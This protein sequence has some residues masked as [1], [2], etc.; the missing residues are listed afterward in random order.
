MKPR[1]V[2]LASTYPRW[3]DDHEPSF[4]H[5][6]ARRLTD[7][8]E[9]VAVV[10]HAP[11]AL[12]RET[13]DDVSILRYRYAP[14]RFETL[15]NDGGIVTHL[16]RSPWKWLLVPTFILMQWI[17]ARRHLKDGAVVHAHWIIPQ[18]VIARLLRRP[19]LITSH[20]ADLFAL[21]GR[22]A[23]SAKRYALAACRAVTVVSEAMRQPATSL[24]RT[25]KISVLPMG[26]DLRTRFTPD[27]TVA[28][29]P[30]HLLFVG[31]LVEKKGVDVLILALS[32]VAA[33][34]PAVRLTVVGHGPFLDA[35][36]AL[37][38][39]EGVANRIDFVGPV[40]Q[41]QLPALYRKAS[42]FV[43]PFRE[44]T[45][46]DVEG[47][48]LVLVEALG[49]GCPI[50]TSDVPATRDVLQGVDGVATVAPNDVRELARA[51]TSALSAI[52]SMTAGV[53]ASRSVLVDRFDWNCV[54]KRYGDLL[55]TVLGEQV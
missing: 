18:G 26:V 6:L 3:K 39:A 43:A 21:K 17:T 15:V 27:P 53:V 31:R 7:R 55:E 29:D 12:P 9:V 4:V 34:H 1:L 44:A 32:E 28:R 51:L 30:C 16:R 52:V 37:A 48:G 54:A 33:V 41:P 8:F 50:V 38:S 35:W 11:G 14:A 10:P 5:E 42:L 13:L 36:Q 24:S 19:Y 2:V 47:L 45:G 22:A 25:V 49:C 20:G 40:G 23:I 46:G